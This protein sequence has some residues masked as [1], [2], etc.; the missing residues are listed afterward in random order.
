MEIFTA[1]D[2]AGMS[3]QAAR[4]VS[5]QLLLKPDCV[6]GLA[7]GSTPLGLYSRLIEEYKNGDLDFTEVRTVN[8]DEYKGLAPGNP[9]SYGYYMRENLFR[10]INIKP[11]N[12]FIPNGLATDAAGECARYDALL[13]SLGIDLQILGLGENGH[14]GFNEP[15][16]V[17]MPSTHLV[18]LTKSTLAANAR[19]FASLDDVPVY[20]YTM[21]IGSILRAKRILLIASGPKKAAALRAALYGPVTPALPASAL[22]LHGYVTVIADAEAMA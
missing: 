15:G 16:E 14:I 8:L 20:A 5:A 12:T 3:R 22:Q 4:L 13:D 21:G 19:Y 9:Q 17:F 7:T 18:G 6:L 11:E 1:T 2:Y 10:H